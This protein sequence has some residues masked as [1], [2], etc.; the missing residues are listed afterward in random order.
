MNRN[1]H[2]QTML[3]IP[4]LDCLDCAEPIPDTETAFYWETSDEEQFWM[5]SLPTEGPLCEECWV[6]RDN[7]EPPDPDGEAFRGGE[8]AA[9]E[10]EQQA[11]IQRERK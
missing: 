7:Y 8:A 11:R 4:A 2:A 3:S 6:K 1:R 5:N 10:A 9:Y